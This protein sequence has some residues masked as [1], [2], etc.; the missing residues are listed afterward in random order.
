MV[1]VEPNDDF[2]AIAQRNCAAYPNV[3]LQHCTFEEC[4]VEPRFFDGVVAASAMHWVSADMAYKKSAN[5]LA[6]DGH[7]ILLWNM[8]LQPS[9]EINRR[10]L[11]TYRS[12]VPDLIRPETD[13]PETQQLHLTRFG[14]NVL[15]SGYFTDL[16]FHSQVVAVRYS[17]DDY[18][19]LLSTYSQYLALDVATRDGLFAD[20]K[21]AI[22]DDFGG[23]LDLTYRSACHVARKA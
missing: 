11:P 22:A 13:N 23:S 9:A 18:I 15:G 3:T 19:Q 7:L 12:R 16:I 2:I 6:S 21:Q 20:I 1:G 4:V 8:V 17:A 14:Q 5:A 10:L